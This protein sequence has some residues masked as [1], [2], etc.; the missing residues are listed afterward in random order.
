MMPLACSVVSL[1]LFIGRHVSLPGLLREASA[2]SYR[3]SSMEGSMA[4][5]PKKLLAWN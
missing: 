1:A 4:A 2:L 3:L 5:S